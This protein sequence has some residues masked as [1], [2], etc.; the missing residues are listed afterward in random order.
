MGLFEMIVLLVLIGT[1]GK[2]GTALVGR[3]SRALTTG[4]DRRIQALEAE[5]RAAEERLALTEDR[6]VDLSEK[7]S[8]VENLLDTPDR[9]VRL[10]PT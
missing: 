1:A 7:V 4:A 9:K 6:I 2:V 3:S 10:P 5:L 8:F